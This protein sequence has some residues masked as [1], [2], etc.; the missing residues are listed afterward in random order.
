MLFMS[1]L[2]KYG[3][4]VGIVLLTLLLSWIVP[5]VVQKIRHLC[6]VRSNGIQEAQAIAAWGRRYGVSCNVCHMNGYK[7]TSPGQQFLRR[8]H[9]M[10]GTEKDTNLSDH[11]SL[12]AKI[13]VWSDTSRVDEKGKPATNT[14]KNSFEEHALSLYAGGPLD[15][16]FS[17]FAEMYL[18]E[19][20]KKNPGANDETTESDMGDWGRSKLAETYLQWNSA[21]EDSYFT[22]K[23]GRVAPSLLHFHNLGARLAYSR[24]T[25]IS[26]NFGDNP[27]RPFSRQF[28]V[29]AGAGIKDAFFEAGLV[30]GTGKYENS[31]E[32]E[33]DTEKDIWLTG[34]Y[35]LGD[36]GSMLG[37]YYYKGKFPLQKLKTPKGAG[38]DDFYSLG[39][40]GNYTIPKGAIIASYYFQEGGYRKVGGTSDTTYGASTMFVELQGYLQGDLLGPYVRYELINYDPDRG[41]LNDKQATDVASVGINWKPFTFGRFVLEYN[42]VSKH[43]DTSAVNYK[44]T[45]QNTVTLEA[46]FMF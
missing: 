38:P 43:E 14:N 35:S 27:Y 19:N 5:P 23:F 7:L 33:G 2:K 21:G 45:K 26:T 32:I 31:V 30:N 16:G 11:L 24:P 9:T 39:V 28:G 20:E 22:T 29:T 10:S 36:Q 15:K 41:A 34:D 13:R 46:Q 8:G 6:P 12:T 42:N 17:Y 1:K 44:D 18:H 25:A 4:S 37:L 3:S 40:V